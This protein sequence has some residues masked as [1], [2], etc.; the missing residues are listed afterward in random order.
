MPAGIGVGPVGTIQVSGVGERQRVSACASLFAKELCVRYGLPL[1]RFDQ[2]P[3]HLLLSYD[4]SKI[5]LLSL[6]KEPKIAQFSDIPLKI[7]N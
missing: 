1:C 2:P 4:I 7:L 3:L 5:H 6:I